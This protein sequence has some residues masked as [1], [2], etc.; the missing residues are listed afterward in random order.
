MLPGSQ[1]N[2]RNMKLIADLWSRLKDS[3]LY[4]ILF[5]KRFP[6]FKVEG[7]CKMRGDCCKSLI[8]T[9]RG[10]PV[11]SQRQF[12]KL[13]KEHPEYEMFIQHEKKYDDGY[14]RYSCS[15]LGEDNKCCI[16]P[17]RP[18]ICRKYPDPWMIKMGGGLLPG[19][20]YRIVPEESFEE[21]LQAKIKKGS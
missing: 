10:Q 9:Y 15:K 20:G 5:E 1:T 3:R 19:C 18:D 14:F 2:I 13:L 8:L 7:A 21:V 12:R 11:R 17:E 16:H 6:R 4:F